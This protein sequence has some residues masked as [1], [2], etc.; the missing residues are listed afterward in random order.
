MD[1]F[2]PDSDGDEDV[3]HPLSASQ[4][5]RD[6]QQTPSVRDEVDA[7]SKPRGSVVGNNVD[8][9]DD[10]EPPPSIVLGTQS[11]R[12]QARTPQEAFNLHGNL[13]PEAGPSTLRESV[14]LDAL[15]RSTNAP[16][17]HHSNEADDSGEE[18]Y[19][20]RQDDGDE[21]AGLM[22]PRARSTSSSRR[23]KD[24]GFFH[25]I[26]RKVRKRAER[27]QAEHG[28]ENGMRSGGGGGGAAKGLNPRERA[29]WQ[30]G[31]LQNMDEFL[32]EVSRRI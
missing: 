6:N 7:S 23:R 12:E 14:R 31:T 5:G 4:R 13:S 2:A 19:E 27:I 30:W 26:T 29:L 32:Q 16:T 20:G 1:P 21:E 9:D 24:R 28:A 25:S 15:G 22:N 3:G 18:D 11:Q 17:H 10:D 8:D